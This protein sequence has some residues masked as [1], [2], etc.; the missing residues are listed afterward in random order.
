MIYIWLN[1]LPILVSAAAGL[2]AGTGWRVLTGAARRPG[3]GP[4]LIAFAAQAWFAAILAGALI[5]APPK[6]NPW[7]IALGTSFIIWIGFVAPATIVTLHA[8]GERSATIAS[9]C[10]H[11]LAVMLTQS[12]VL[13]L[14]GLVPPPHG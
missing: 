8:R 1:L 10:G 7:V 11:W 9:E 4:L 6:A 2:V 14:I 13:H 5:L 12:I 3:T